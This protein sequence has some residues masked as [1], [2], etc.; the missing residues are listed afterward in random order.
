MVLV[1][2][3]V[4][5]TYTGSLYRLIAPTNFDQT[6]YRYLVTVPDPNPVPSLNAVG[7]AKYF[8]A[9]AFQKKSGDPRVYAVHGS[10]PN[11]PKSLRS[12]AFPVQRTRPSSPKL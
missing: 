6:G 5:T 7:F 12:R 8:L 4:V 1:R 2:D 3:D 10:N 11:Q 9:S